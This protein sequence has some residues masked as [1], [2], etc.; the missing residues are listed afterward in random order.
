MIAKANSLVSIP[1][2]VPTL[3]TSKK[4]IKGTKPTKGVPC[5]LSKMARRQMKI[6][7]IARN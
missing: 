7:D 6:I 4:S 3:R 5:L 2:A 1:S